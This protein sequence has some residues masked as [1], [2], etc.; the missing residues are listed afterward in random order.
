LDREAASRAE[1]VA[2]TGVSRPQLIEEAM[3]AT[4]EAD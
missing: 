3:R 4:L 1:L 2:G